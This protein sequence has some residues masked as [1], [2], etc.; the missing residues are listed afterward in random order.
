MARV[1]QSFTVGNWTV[2]VSLDRIDRNGDSISLRPQVMELLAH[3]AQRPG[4]VVSADELREAL[5]PQRVVTDASIYTCVAELRRALDSDPAQIEYVQT[6][7]KRGYR[8][9]APIGEAPIR[10]PEGSGGTLRAG[11]LLGYVCVCSPRSPHSQP[12]A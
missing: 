11:R 12:G 8:L 9:V 7:P 3:L 1:D 10:S 4:V 6:V 5:W 2:E